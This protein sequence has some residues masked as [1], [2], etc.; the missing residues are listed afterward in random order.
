MEDSQEIDKMLIAVNPAYL[1]EEIEKEHGGEEK[2]DGSDSLNKI[3]GILMN[4][5]LIISSMYDISADVCIRS[6]TSLEA[7]LHLIYDKLS[8][9]L[10]SNKLSH[11]IEFMSVSSKAHFERELI[12]ENVH[13]L[14]KS[15]SLLYK[16]SKIGNSYNTPMFGRLEAKHIIND[17]IELAKI[18]HYN[19]ANIIDV[20]RVVN[21]E[22]EYKC[23]ELILSCSI[24]HYRDNCNRIRDMLN[25]FL[26]S[27]RFNPNILEYRNSNILSTRSIPFW[28]TK[29]IKANKFY[30]QGNSEKKYV[31][32]E[33]ETN[34]KTEYILELRKICQNDMHLYFYGQILFPKLISSNL[35]VTD[36][37]WKKYDKY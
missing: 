21:S 35:Q 10:N 25:E 33:S 15:Y 36:L 37:E 19:K 32:S 17:N 18:S 23:Y 20:F 30:L 16:R 8:E 1:Y 11:A 7:S 4:I 22:N 31:A 3:K 27:V 28:L 2:L 34:K 9:Q 29:I 13:V 26:C 5:L 12:D 24:Q 14:L 6:C